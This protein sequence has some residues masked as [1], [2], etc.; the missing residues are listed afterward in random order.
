MF[1]L[2]TG[3]PWGDLAMLRLQLPDPRPL[4]EATPEAIGVRSSVGSRGALGS[5][6]AQG[7][8]PMLP[9]YDPCRPEWRDDPYPVYRELRNRAPVQLPT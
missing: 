7:V 2:R 4:A 3:L 6:C 5:A 8:H 9:D 1:G